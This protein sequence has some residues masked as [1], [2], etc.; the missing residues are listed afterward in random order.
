MRS[1]VQPNI[2]F[3][4][5]GCRT[6]SLAGEIHSPFILAPAIGEADPRL[7]EWPASWRSSAGFR[8]RPLESP[9]PWR[10]GPTLLPTSANWTRADEYPRSPTRLK[11][12]VLR[13]ESEALE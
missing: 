10:G 9:L 4:D 2:V 12:H 11:R 8:R 7:P 3:G 1:E 6:A 5:V 13:A